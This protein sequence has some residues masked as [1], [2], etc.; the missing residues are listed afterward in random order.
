M[1]SRSQTPSSPSTVPDPHK[2]KTG[3]EPMT[4]AQRRELE[5]LTRA[6][7]EDLD[8]DVV[9]TKAEAELRIDELR[10]AASRGETG[11]TVED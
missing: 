2:W 1:S 4:P 10:R 3:D 11:G 7:G 5:T 8:P 9:L 6:A